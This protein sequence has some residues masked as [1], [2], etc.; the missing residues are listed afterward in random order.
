[1]EKEFITFASSVLSGVYSG[2]AIVSIFSEFS[3]KFEKPGLPYSTVPNFKSKQEIFATNLQHFSDVEKYEIINYLTEN[4]TIRKRGYG[5]ASDIT[6]GLKN[7]LERKFYYLNKEGTILDFEIIESTKHWLSNYPKSL[8]NYDIAIQQYNEKRYTRNI[9]DNIRLSLE[10]LVK[11]IFSNDRSLENQDF[12]A[13][14]LKNLKE[15]GVSPEVRNMIHKLIDYLTKYQNTYVKHD[16]NIDKS[17]VE[18]VIELT[19]TIMKFLIREYQ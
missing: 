14:F 11:D 2:R 4:S 5:T 12:T 8:E 19:S 1:M 6:E 13:L 7:T 16:D 9:L 18:V 3:L 15:G 10:L 17:E